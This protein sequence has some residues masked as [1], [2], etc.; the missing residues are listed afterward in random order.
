M[1]KNEYRCSGCNEIKNRINNKVW[2]AW[3]KSK[4]TQSFKSL[5]AGMCRK[6]ASSQRKGETGRKLSER[7]Q[8]EQIF[9]NV[10]GL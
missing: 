10:R 4:E 8:W 2:V 1:K 5:K 7:I 3:F 6:C 9:K